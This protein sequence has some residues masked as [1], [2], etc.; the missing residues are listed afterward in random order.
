MKEKI[1]RLLQRYIDN[2]EISG[3]SVLLY[4]DGRKLLRVDRGYA[5]IAAGIPYSED[6]II[7]LYSMTKPITSAAVMIL[8]ERGLLDRLDP[9]SNYIS[10]FASQ[11]YYAK[12]G[13]KK[14]VSRR[15]TIGDLLDMTGGMSYPDPATPAGM[16]AD[17]VFRS[18][19]N[20][21]DT[22][23]QMSTLE[24]A[25]AL[26]ACTL[27]FDPGSDYLYS[28]CADILGAIVEKVSGV[29]F[30]QFLQKELFDPLGMNDTGF[31]V[32]DDRQYRLARSYVP[33]SHL[34]GTPENE[35]PFTD[36]DIHEY[37]GNNLGIMS[38]MDREPAFES[39]GAGLAS[40]LNDYNRFAQ[41]L[42]NGGTAPSGQKILSPAT[43]EFMTAH[44]ASAIAEAGFHK[45]FELQGFSYANLLRIGTSPETCDTLMCP[46]E[47]GWDGWLGPYFANIPSK[48][49]TL[50]I[51][52]QR[53]NSGTFS[54]T[55]RVR[56]IILAEI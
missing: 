56:N 15:M 7:R 4:K 18:I 5:D 17:L 1:E 38:R 29:R 54:L 27:A 13:C 37:T 35:I 28:T 26:G 49:A 40:T 25:E 55:R 51:A 21:L 12:D 22:K 24:V 42:L 34:H 3:A 8:I 47:Y 50:L 41:M 16:D 48:N 52:M 36:D 43:V 6:T 45:R 53:T 30:S 19:E 20:R 39:G 11:R 9:V 33:D 32:P 2:R 14:N 44:R 46:G 31:Y 10:S 23:E